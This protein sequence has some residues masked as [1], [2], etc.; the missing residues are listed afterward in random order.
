M[1]NLTIAPNV[2]LPTTTFTLASGTGAGIGT[3]A[4]GK[5]TVNGITDTTQTLT[6]GV[7]TYTQVAADTANLKILATRAAAASVGST[8]NNTA[9]GAALDT[10][11]AGGGSVIQQIQGNL[12]AQ[13][14]AA[15][16]NNILGSLIPTVDGGSQ[17]SALEVTSEVEDITDTRMAALRAN[18][19][20][21]GVAAGATA[22]GVSMWA[23]GYGQGASQDTRDSVAGYSDTT[24]GGAVGVDST[25]LVNDGVLGFAVNYGKS[26]VDSKNLN[27]TNTDVDNYGATLYGTLGLGQRMFVDGQVG[28]GYNTINSTRHD[29]NGP[30][31]GVSAYGTTHSDQYDAKLSLGRDY[32]VDYG[33]V[34]TPDVSASYTYLNTS[35]YTETGTGANLTVGSNSQSALDLGVGVKA[36]WKLKNE[37]GSLMKPVVHVG[38]AYDA[39]G[40]KIDTT[41]NFVG[42]PSA[43]FVTSGP[44]PERNK[45]NAGAGVTYMTTANW[46]MSANYNFQYR[47]DYQSHTGTLRLTSHF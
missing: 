11:A 44:S 6:E 10:I 4:A 23:Q 7:M 37:D 30:G 41:A 8:T 40:D 24:W 35:G 29:V 13:T 43:A 12:A 16:V 21:T 25:Q 42:S 3:L 33:T 38:Y 20:S 2:Y 9:V 36:A 31:T 14:T 34:L 45:F 17:A 15:G 22:N 47:S 18:D 5:L 46:D 39:I 26:T 19:G 32:P 1:V 27:T 28:Y